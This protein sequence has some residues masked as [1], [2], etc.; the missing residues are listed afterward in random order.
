MSDPVRDSIPAGH[1]PTLPRRVLI[2]NRGEIAVRIARTC[3][4]MGIDTVAVYADADADAVHVRVCD[5]AVRLPGVAPAQT[6]LRTDLLLDAAARSGADAVHPGYGFL[7]ESADFA[8]AVLDAGLTWIGP[9]PDTIAHMAD[10]LAARRHMAEAGVPLIP[11]TPLSADAD[12]AAVRAAVDEVG[13]PALVKAAAG[14]GGKGMRAVHDRADA[15]ESVAAARREAAAAFGDDR[16]YLER[17]VER[18]RHVEVQV[19]GDRHGG[20]V[21][22]LERECSIQRRHQKIVEE[23]PSPG[24]DDAVRAAITDAAVAAARAIGYVGAGTVE[25]VADESRLAARRAGEPVAPAD[26]FSFLEVNTR[27]QVEHPVTE[28]VVRLRDAATG[29]LRPLD[30]VRWQLLVAAGLALDVDQ[31]DVVGSGHAIEVRLYAEDPAEDDLP[32]TGTLERFEPAMRPGIRWDAG[33]D[34]GAVVTVHYDP[35]LAKVIAAA[36]TRAEAAS[37]LAAELEDT[38]LVGVTTNRDLLVALLRDPAFLAGETTTAFLSEHRSRLLAASRPEPAD[39]DLAAVVAAVCRTVHA[40]R[41]APVLST[42]PPGFTN[43]ATLPVQHTFRAASRDDAAGTVDELLTVRLD[44]ERDGTYRGTVHPG[45]AA[46]RLDDA[47]AR[48]TLTVAVQAVDGD[49]LDVEVA[50]VRRR[51][52]VV[53]AGDGPVQVRI[54]GRR[55]ELTPV[56]RLATAAR[57]L[58]EGAMIAPMPGTVV[59]VTV[60]VGDTVGVGQRLVTVEAMKMEHSVTAA[61]PGTVVEIAVDAGQQVDAD[62]VLVVVE[63]ADGGD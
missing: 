38:A 29:Q 6:Y 34:G 5:A 42:L 57:E 15:V 30:L 4:A 10:K 45:L 40:H 39:R 50:G 35:M 3:R 52:Q 41:R 1:G 22:L 18:P 9:P 20:L 49:H 46:G 51:A 31:S 7:A 24:I 21:H 8:R 19:L 61:V 12:A 55:T 11:G 47:V 33:V 28:S 56:P 25:F 17:L 53:T 54:D 44:A 32:A 59:D 63:P 48:S 36:P 2:A 26:C 14:G 37:Q 58:P 23:S 27:L 16:V 62:E 43:A 60:G 13:L